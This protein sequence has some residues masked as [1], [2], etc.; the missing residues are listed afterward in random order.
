M[1]SAAKPEPN[2]AAVSQEGLSLCACAMLFQAAR[3]IDTFPCEPPVPGPDPGARQAFLRGYSR[4]RRVANDRM[5]ALLWLTGAWDGQISC[6]EALD[7]ARV[8]LPPS[9]TFEHAGFL[10]WLFSMADSGRVGSVFASVTMAA[11]HRAEQEDRDECVADLH[12]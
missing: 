9:N 11:P 8:H 7:V 5:S 2:A 3:D 1:L 12:E 10:A 6:D 4:Y